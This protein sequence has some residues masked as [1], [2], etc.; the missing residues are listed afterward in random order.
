MSSSTLDATDTQ[1]VALLQVN[2]RTSQADIA[3]AL[4]IAPSAVLERIRKLESRGVITGYAALV[5][6]AAFDARLLAFIAVRGSSGPGDDETSQLLAAVPEVLE[7]HHVAGEDC[8]FLKVRAR[9]PQHIAEILRTRIKAIS[10]ITSTRTTI[11]LETIKETP[12]LPLPT[13]PVAQEVA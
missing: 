13:P 7:V 11:V 2:G 12:R 5:D 10:G 9:D 1:I 4:D 8:Y 6:P 3:R